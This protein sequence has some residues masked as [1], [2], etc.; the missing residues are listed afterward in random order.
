LG[1]RADVLA[2]EKNGVKHVNVEKGA[3]FNWTS[4]WL[5]EN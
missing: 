2:S 5:A 3:W 4:S 1:S